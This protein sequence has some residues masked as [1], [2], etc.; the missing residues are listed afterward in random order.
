MLYIIAFH[1]LDLL[2]RL[3]ARMKIQIYDRDPLLALSRSVSVDINGKENQP[4]NLD[5]SLLSRITWKCR[6]I[7]IA[8]T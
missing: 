1:Q 8:L 4:E 3:V 5:R 2:K 6:C 7:K